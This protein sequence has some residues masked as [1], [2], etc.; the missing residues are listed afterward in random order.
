MS[1]YKRLDAWK[2]AYSLGLEIYKCSR[3]FPKE[4]LYGI[5]S[6]MRRAATSIAANIAEGNTRRSRKEYQQFISVARGSAAELET[7]LMFARDLDYIDKITFD[8]LYSNLDDVKAL[9]YR[10]LKS[11]E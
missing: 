11:L 8:V 6:Q 2:K 4:E 5:T 3:S 10:L 7:W 9:L 1:M